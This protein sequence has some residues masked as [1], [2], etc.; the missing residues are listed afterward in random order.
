MA[1]CSLEE[2]SQD[3]GTSGKQLLEIGDRFASSRD[4]T[5]QHLDHVRM[6]LGVFPQLMRIVSIY[7]TFNGEIH[8]GLPD[9]LPTLLPVHTR[10]FDWVVCLEVPYASSYED[11]VWCANVRIYPGEQLACVSDGLE[12]V[13]YQQHGSTEAA[14]GEFLFH[15]CGG[16]EAFGKPLRRF[17]ILN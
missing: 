16:R 14:A 10:D 13:E 6:S 9:Q 8:G 4:L 12:V 15:V 1:I 3:I 2:S 5:E 17:Q 11:L 7:E